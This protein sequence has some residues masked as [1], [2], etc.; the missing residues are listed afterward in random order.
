[1]H[2]GPAIRTPAADANHGVI[3]VIEY[4]D[5]GPDKKLNE[6]VMA[7][8][9]DAGI[10]GGG[11]NVQ[12][13]DRDIYEQAKAG[14]RIFD[15]RIALATTG[16]THDG[17]K[18]AELKAFHADKKLVSNKTTTRHVGSLGT[19]QQ[20]ERSKLRGGAFGMNL[21]NMLSQAKRFVDENPNEFLLLKFDKS[22]N[23]LLIAEACVNYLGSALYTGGG[24][25]NTQ[26]LRDL[27]GKVVP[28]FVESGMQALRSANVNGP[29]IGILGIKNMK[30]D[31]GGYNDRYEGIQYYGKGG[32]SPFSPFKKTKQNVTKQSDLMKKGGQGNPAVMGMMYWTSTGLFESI[33]DRNDGMWTQPNVDKLKRMWSQGLEQAIQDRA[34]KYA[35]INGFGG[36]QR[37]KAFLPNFVMIDF[38][39]PTKCG[40]IFEL[41][42]T[43]VTVMV[44][45]FGLGQH[46]IRQA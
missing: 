34:G 28:L 32:T 9:H 41:N 4:Y 45:A 22:T 37:L 23:W 36:G 15:L 31:K 38:A 11:S 35:Q 3:A 1:M 24:N 30:D 16:G 33:K 7:G 25:L 46:R 43:P 19:T 2:V 18:L 44:D 29:G 13:Q 6:I 17:A 20:V 27:R 39:D 8:S 21:S 10:T 14:V 42:T 5:L 12:T 26:T 40:E